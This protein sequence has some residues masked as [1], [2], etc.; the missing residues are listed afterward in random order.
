MT[1]LYTHPDYTRVGYLESALKEAGIACFVQ[2]A[3]SQTYLTGIPSPL[4]YPKLCLTHDKDSES[5]NARS[6]SGRR[7]SRARSKSLS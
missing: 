5:E 2:N 7:I 1:E 3:T 4:F 6:I